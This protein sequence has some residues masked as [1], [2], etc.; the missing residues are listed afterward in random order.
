[1]T[2]DAK[3]ALHL[4]NLIL[5]ISPM[6]CILL[7]FAC[8]SGISA[9]KHAT[10]CNFAFHLDPRRG[11][12]SQWPL[13]FWLTTILVYFLAAG[14]L[15][16]APYTLSFTPEGFDTFID[17]SRFPLALLSLTIPVGVFISRLHSTQQT[18]AQIE[19]TDM[20]N[21]L[22]AFHAQRKGIVEYIAS[23]GTIELAHQVS[24]KIQ[25]NQ[26][27]HSVVFCNSTHETGAQE[28]DER[29]MRQIMWQVE[30]ILDNLA[31]LIPNFEPL[32]DRTSR[33]S[34]FDESGIYLELMKSVNDLCAKLSVTDYVIDPQNKRTTFKAIFPGGKREQYVRLAGSYH[35]LIAILNYCIT[36]SFYAMVSENRSSR[37]LESRL[38]MG[39]LKQELHTLGLETLH[40]DDSIKSYSTRTIIYP[41][42][43]L[44]AV[45]EPS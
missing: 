41:K 32:K 15:C 13:R 40:Y 2:Q 37:G 22:D 3:D 43:I 36:V 4:I 17:I 24:L 33:K 25:I 45:S 42:P 39:R 8:A 38:Q 35:E 6:A 16:W 29:T 31:R 5:V 1:M 9:D 14:Y 44:E 19:A 34:R 26:A 7:F 27:F 11:L 18:A 10:F 21:R 20:K 23:L 30:S 12:A 28:A